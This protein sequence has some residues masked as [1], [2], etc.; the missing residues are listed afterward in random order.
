MRPR[1]LG[2]VAADTASK[3]LKRYGTRQA[4]DAPPRFKEVKCRLEIAGTGV[5]KLCIELFCNALGR[6]RRHF[7]PGW[8]G[9]GKRSQRSTLRFPS[10]F[11][12]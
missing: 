3:H 7:G 11:P 1:V 4:E 10:L 12:N 5:S 2:A 8:T 9:F 6:A